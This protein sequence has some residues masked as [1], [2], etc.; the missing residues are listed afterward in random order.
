[1]FGYGSGRKFLTVDDMYFY[2]SLSDHSSSP[3]LLQL[4]QRGV[5]GVNGN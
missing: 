3:P 4:L 2:I 1:M 5:C